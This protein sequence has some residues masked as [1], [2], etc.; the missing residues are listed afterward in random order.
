M[1]MKTANCF[2]AL[3][4]T[5]C[6]HWKTFTYIHVAIVEPSCTGEHFHTSGNMFTSRCNPCNSAKQWEI[7]SSFSCFPR[8]FMIYL[9]PKNSNRSNP[10]V[11]N[12]SNWWWCRSMHQRNHS[13]TNQFPLPWIPE[14]HANRNEINFFPGTDEGNMCL[15]IVDG[16]GWGLLITIK[17]HKNVG[18]T[19][20][21]PYLYGPWNGTM[22]KE[23]L[24]G[25]HF[26][27]KQAGF[28]T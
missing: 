8:I 7:L 10:R 4:K 28:P 11:Q 23:T 24:F 14:I 27:K 13:N 17:S 9:K 22:T 3:Y 21:N 19:L 1:N 25:I 2:K 16:C 26:V 6:R 18:K 5:D 15:V 20:K 12:P